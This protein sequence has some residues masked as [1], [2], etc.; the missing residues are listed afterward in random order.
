MEKDYSNL[1]RGLVLKYFW[2]VI[3]HFK[4]S[5]FAVIILT[6]ITSA[7]DVFIPLQYLKLWNVLSINNFT[8]IEVAKSIIIFILLLNFLRWVLRRISGFSLSYFEART[9][10]GLREQAF[11][12]LIGHS[13][14]FF[15]NN[16][17]GSLT[18]RINKYARAFERIT[19]RIMTDGLPL[20]VRSLG[21]VIAIYSLFPKYSYILGIFCIVF[22]LTAFIYIHYKLKY[23]IIASETD[24]RTTG[25]LSDSI[26]NH[27]SIQLFTGHEYEK[28]HMGKII[29]DQRKKTSF[30]WY[31]WEGLGAIESFYSL[32]IEFIIFWVVLGDWKLGL[33]TLP[34]IVLLQ[35]YLIRLIENLWSFGAIVR[36]YYESFADAEEMAVILSTPYEIMDKPAQVAEALFP[37]V[38]GNK[39]SATIGKV[40]FDKITYIYA[41]NYYKVLDNFSLT[42]PAGQKI[43][44][45]GSSGA[46]KTTFVRLLMRLFNINSGRILI[47]GID[48]SDISQKSLREK[49]SFVPQDPVLFHRTLLEN[50]RYGRRDATDEE[51]L[52]AAHLAHCDEF[53]DA[54]PNGYQTY[55][56]ER[57]IKLSGG[58]R[59]RVAI[60]RAILK[61]AP[62]LILDEATSS[63]DSHSESL[64]QDAFHTLIKGKT[65]IVIAHRLSTIREMDR[66]IVL[67]K[68]KIIE[69]GTHEKLANK[70]DGLY[71][72]LWDLQ[73]GGFKNTI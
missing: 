35:N 38:S 39:A 63:L 61:N 51:V 48:I 20:F 33:I 16:F 25:A 32:V 43:A 10:A 15:A 62:I 2:Q 22:L 13:H 17:S 68:G 7:L 28:E 29:E 66:I 65:T 23:D 5:F 40:I 3:K 60:A 54:L 46:G 1:H 57:G 49:I 36:T 67:E 37:L 56:G 24:S 41:D 55:V 52:T 30:N 69:D 73:A 45:V 27:S 47:D 70:K 4:V 50:I 19:D 14:S 18:Q 12:Y 42:I 6:I 59:Q 71:K 34:V 31:L 72:K 8:V 53:I 9:M 58:E 21:T 44:I 26:S 64:I 11:D